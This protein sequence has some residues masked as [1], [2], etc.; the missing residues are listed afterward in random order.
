MK[1]SYNEIVDFLK[2]RYLSMVP[3]RDVVE[4]KE[5]VKIL[6]MMTDALSPNNRLKWSIGAESDSD[7][8]LFEQVQPFLGRNLL[9]IS[10]K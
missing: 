1:Q 5:R 4:L 7:S 9:L 3:P 2:R 10:T 8:R 6:K